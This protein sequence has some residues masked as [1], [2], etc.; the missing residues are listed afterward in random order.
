MNIREDPQET[1]ISDITGRNVTIR[2]A[3]DWDL[4]E[5][6]EYLK[7]HGRDE[8]EIGDAE[9]VVA[10]EQGHLLGFGILKKG[11]SVNNAYCLSITEMSGHEGMGVAIVQHL[12]DYVSVDTIYTSD[13]KAA[14][15]LSH[16]GFSPK[17]MPSKMVTEEAYMV[18]GWRG[19]GFG[20]F[21]RSQDRLGTVV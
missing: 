7:T 1:G 4:V 14:A 16:E 17:N 6:R 20:A 10:A 12:L 2:H 5:L 21:A 13:P 18:C 19:E 15:Y 3:N 8:A 9:V 11:R